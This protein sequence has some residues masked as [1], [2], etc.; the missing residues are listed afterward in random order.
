MKNG[1]RKLTDDEDDEADLEEIEE[2]NESDALLKVNGLAGATTLSIKGLH[3]TL[4]ITL[5]H[6]VECHDLFILM[7]NVIMLSVVAPIG[8]SAFALNGIWSNA[9]KP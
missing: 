1:K 3:M 8:A 6:Y 7:V 9:G 5:C 2:E 4:S